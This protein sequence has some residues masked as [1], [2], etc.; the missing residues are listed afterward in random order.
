MNLP[1]E[2]YT[3][4]WIVWVLYFLVLE[5]LALAD[6]DRHD[7]FSEYVWSLRNH[8]GSFAV[9]MV[10]ALALWLAFHFIVEGR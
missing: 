10:S 9:F 1:A 3:I 6:P 5:G 4:G 8:G 7:T 2:A